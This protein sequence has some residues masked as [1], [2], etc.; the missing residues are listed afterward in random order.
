IALHRALVAELP[1]EPRHRHDLADALHD[2][3]LLQADT[4]RTEEAG[5]AFEEALALD[6]P[7]ARDHADVPAYREGVARRRIALGDLWLWKR[8][9]P[10]RALP[11]YRE[12]MGLLRIAEGSEAKPSQRGL[13][14]WTHEKYANAL[15]RSG[16]DSAEV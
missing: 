5:A 4:A 10:R 12:A 9:D 8:K 13:L 3:G 11:Q 2:L 7:L 1:D 16:G 14:G 6:E 15:R